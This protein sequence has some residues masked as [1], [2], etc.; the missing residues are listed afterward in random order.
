MKI[1]LIPSDFEY[2]L[3]VSENEAEEAV[4]N[5]AENTDCE[6]ISSSSEEFECNTSLS[7]IIVIANAPAV[8]SALHVE[9]QHVHDI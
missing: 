2:A 7:I 8:K 5:N 6:I 1:S 4:Q 9:V 3:D